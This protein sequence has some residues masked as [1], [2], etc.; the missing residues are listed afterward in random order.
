MGYCQTYPMAA[1]WLAG[2]GPLERRRLLVPAAADGFVHLVLSK[3]F[4]I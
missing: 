1:P 3:V 4:V 2:P